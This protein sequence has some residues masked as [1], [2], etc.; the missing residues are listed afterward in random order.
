MKVIEVFLC[1]AVQLRLSEMILQWRL[2]L[3]RDNTKY[4]N[5]VGER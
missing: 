4:P 1:I 2:E 3:S 5:G